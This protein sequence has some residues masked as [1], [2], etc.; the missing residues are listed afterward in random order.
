MLAKILHDV[1]STFICDGQLGFILGRKI[2][3]NIILPHELVKA[4]TRKNIS[5]R[6]MLKINLQKAYDFVEWPYL[7]QMLLALGFPN[8]FTKWVVLCVK[9]VSY[10]IIVNKT[11]SQHFAANKGLRQGDPI[12]PLLFTIAMKYLIDYSR[13]SIL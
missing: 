11:A 12:S 1:V 5:L 9:T 13:G 7:E 6:S 3:D 4:Y 2:Q 10:A 8:L